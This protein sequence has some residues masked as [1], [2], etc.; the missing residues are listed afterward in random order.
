MFAG[1]NR[2]MMYPLFRRSAL[3]ALC[4]LAALSSVAA[5]PPDDDLPI[6]ETDQIRSQRVAFITQQLNLS[7]SEAGHFWTIYS[8]YEE[9]RRALLQ[10]FRD[11]D[12][13]TPRNDAEANELIEGRFQLEED[14][15]NLKR[16]FYN[17]LRQHIS[18]RKL[19]LLPKAERDFRRALLQRL[20]ER[21]RG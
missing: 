3:L 12:L 5:Q 15:L 1:K 9:Q 14:L 13:R 21:R 16:E 20:R 2:P 17:R 8:D 19:A 6:P 18:P 11:E 7:P 10:G 4:F